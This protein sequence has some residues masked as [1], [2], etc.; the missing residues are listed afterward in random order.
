M[1]RLVKIMIFVMLVGVLAISFPVSAATGFTITNV[2]TKVSGVETT[3]GSNVTFLL[4]FD[5]K[6]ISGQEIDQITITIENSE[7]QLIG[8]G[9][10]VYMGTDLIN[11]DD[12][13]FSD[14]VKRVGSTETQIPITINYEIGG[15][16]YSQSESI[17]INASVSSST[18]STPT[19]TSKYQPVIAFVDP[20]FPIIYQGQLNEMTLALK[21]SASYQAKYVTVTPDYA[22]L[23]TN[24]IRLNGAVF[25]PTETTIDG[26]KSGDFKLTFIVDDTVAA[27]TY[28]LSLKVTY[29][30]PYGDEFESTLA[31]YIKVVVAKDEAHQ[32]NIKLNTPVD[33]A[34]TNGDDLTLDLKMTNDAEKLQDFTMDFGTLPEGFVKLPTSSTVKYA[35]LNKFAIRVN[36]L[37]LHVSDSVTTGWYEIPVKYSYVTEDGY[38]LNRIETFTIY[39]NGE[40][41]TSG[42]LET[43]NLSYPSS[44]ALDQS[45]NVTFDLSNPSEKQVSNV[46]VS[47]AENNIFIP[48]SNSH[49]Q[50][51][52]LKSGTNESVSFQLVG[53]GENVVSR[54]YPIVFNIA[55]S[56]EMDGQT[57]EKSYQQILGVYVSGD[58]TS[59]SG[60]VPKIIISSYEADPNIVDA[61]SEFTLNLSF[62]NT[63]KTQS[64][65]NIK[66]FLTATETSE[67]TN[68]NIF[69]PV[70]SSNTFY[71]DDIG[72]KNSSD[73]SIK[74]YAMPDAQPKTYTIQVNFEY[75]DADGNPYTATELVGVNVKQPTKIETLDLN[76]PTEI[77]MGEGYNLYF[78][79]INTGKVKVYNMKVSIEGNVQMEPASQY[80]GTFESGNQ[81]YFDGYMMPSSAGEQ[82]IRVILSYDDPSGEHVEVPQ[83]FTVNVIENFFEPE[84]GGDYVDPMF[85]DDMMFPEENQGLKWYHYAG[86]AAGVIAL[87]VIIIVVLRRRKAKKEGMIIDED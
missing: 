3:I 73:Q 27:G 34:L 70:D 77:F 56:Y 76:M 42:A 19:D 5:L 38:T 80:Y 78:Q 35:A 37:S 53:T 54:N 13:H 20:S 68:N 22:G 47:L 26:N 84:F 79:I 74:L 40:S 10:S 44:V 39:V 7:Y 46:E 55:Y 66:A 71:I 31:T 75:E 28:P 25:S 30:N 82:T 1:K 81:N 85:P 41:S 11:N 43:M 51:G 50:L 21:N 72:P 18:P 24:G 61:G 29:E 12:L 62:F 59:Q 23:L 63:N 32:V 57:V 17:S 14:Y 48:K 15:T 33:P 9:S 87:V 4:E 16:A 65:Y 8:S 52:D 86:I 64:I 69:I 2:T 83:E 45:F 6:N 49:L 58:D 36:S 60:G 67:T